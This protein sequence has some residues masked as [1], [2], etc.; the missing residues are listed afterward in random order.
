MMFFLFFFTPSTAFLSFVVIFVFLHC[1]GR[2]NL[3][4]WAVSDISGLL[5]ARPL[6]QQGLAVGAACMPAQCICVC[7]M[8]KQ[9]VSVSLTVFTVQYV[10]IVQLGWDMETR[11]SNEFVCQFF[12]SP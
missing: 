6:S 1:S 9:H 12:L 11:S 7:P 10:F 2:A 5:T 8:I 3:S 4:L